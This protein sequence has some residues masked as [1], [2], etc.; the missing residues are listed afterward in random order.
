MLEE[1]TIPPLHEYT[2]PSPPFQ[3]SEDAMGRFWKVYLGHEINLRVVRVH[4]LESKAVWVEAIVMS[5]VLG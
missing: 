4:H 3:V 2:S 5:G 1:Q